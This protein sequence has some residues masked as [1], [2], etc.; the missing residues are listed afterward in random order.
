MCS[1]DLADLN[2]GRFSAGEYKRIAKGGKEVW[3]NASYNPIMDASGKPFK[4]VKYAT[5]ITE[6]VKMKV[7]MAMLDCAPFNVMLADKN[8][9]ITYVNPSSLATLKKLQQY[10][11]VP[12]EKVLGSN[13]DIFHKNPL[14]QQ[15]IVGD[16]NNLPRKTVIQ[17]G[18]ESADLL[19]S[20]IFDQSG[21]FLGPMVTWEVITE[22]L[23]TERKIGRAHV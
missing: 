14:H 11:P 2:A 15:K 19:V 9:I 12:A 3:I 13:I 23:E 4:V 18:P 7:G 21:T 6:T 16:K 20:P 17:L 1:S 5:D 10:L 8:R 22:K